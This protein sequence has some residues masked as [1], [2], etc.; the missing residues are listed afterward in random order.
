MG[1]LDDGAMGIIRTL[2]HLQTGIRLSE[3][4]NLRVDDVD[5]EHRLLTVRQGKGKKDW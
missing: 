3:L 5:F 4:V 1:V 2:C